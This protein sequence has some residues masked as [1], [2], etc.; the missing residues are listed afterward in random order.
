MGFL[1]AIIIAHINDGENPFLK[2]Y[3]SRGLSNISKCYFCSSLFSLRIYTLK[4]SIFTHT[5]AK[6]AKISLPDSADK[7]SHETKFR[8]H[9][10]ILKHQQFRRIPALVLFLLLIGDHPLV[11]GTN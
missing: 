6:E 9:V 7:C 1:V 8:E 3:W 11:Q 4:V 2:L 10:R 5:E